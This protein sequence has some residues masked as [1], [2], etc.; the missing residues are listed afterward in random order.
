MPHYLGY[1]SGDPEKEFIPL[2]PYRELR[3]HMNSSVFIENGGIYLSKRKLWEDGRRLGPNVGIISMNW[4]ESIEI[5]EPE[6][7]EAARKLAP[8]F[9]R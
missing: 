7:L 8:M 1:K 5:D 3:Q 9:L 2:Y 4:W 6:D